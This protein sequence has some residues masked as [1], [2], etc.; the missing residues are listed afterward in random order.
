M[1]LGI[2]LKGPEGIVLA[3]D[4]RVILN[5]AVQEPQG[6]KL[7]LQPSYDNAT[8]L[9]RVANQDCIG[10]VTYGLGALGGSN[11]RT[12]H[13]YLPEFEKRLQGRGRLSVEEFAKELS[14]FFLEQWHATMPEN[15]PGQ[16]IVFLIGGYDLDAVYGRV[17]EVDIPT[18]PAPK[19]WHKGN[20]F[21]AVWGG[22]REFTDRLLQ[23]FD[24]GLL[25]L[26]IRTLDLD[27]Q[28]TS[29]LNAALAQLSIPIP[30]Q[31]LPLQDCVDLAILL[32][33]T[34][35]TLQKWQVGTR[36][37]GGYIDV[38]TITRAGFDYVQQKK[39]RGED[40]EKG[41]KGCSN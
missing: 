1:S 18:A 25:D 9:L 3:A 14:D 30:Y 38:A 5:V 26:V 20:E 29:K 28:A 7:I 12:A 24:P 23:G 11:P 10:V 34:T 31:F 22:Q 19:E 2:V 21:G 27:E 36:G 40:I 33:R 41:D 8:K 15:H 17:F 39:I 32:I 35:M 13:S 6:Q 4:S 37:V 16:P